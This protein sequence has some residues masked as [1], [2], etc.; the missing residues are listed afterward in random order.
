MG[1]ATFLDL[2]EGEARI[3]GYATKQGLDDRY[4]TLE[5]LDVGDFLGVVGTVFKTKRGELSIDVADF[6]LLAKALRPPPEKWHGLRDIELRYR[7]RY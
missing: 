7:Q 4:E 6:T 3:Q 1:R 5:L 2:R